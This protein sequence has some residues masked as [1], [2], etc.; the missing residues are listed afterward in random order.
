MDACNEVDHINSVN[1]VENNEDHILQSKTTNQNQNSPLAEKMPQLDSYQLDNEDTNKDACRNIFSSILSK[2][3][4][5]SFI[6]DETDF[7]T[8]INSFI[9]EGTFDTENDL[10]TSQAA[11]IEAVPIHESEDEEDFADEKYFKYRKLD[12]SKLDGHGRSMRKRSLDDKTNLCP[13]CEVTLRP[14][15]VKDHINVEIQKLEKIGTKTNSIYDTSD[16]SELQKQTFLRTMRE[17]R[18]SRSSALA[19]AWKELHHQKINCPVCFSSISGTTDEI[20]SHVDNCLSNESEI[21]SDDEIIN[22]NDDEGYE[23]YTWAGQTRIRASSLIQGGLGASG[24]A[25]VQK[26]DEDIDTDLIVDDD[27]LDNNGESQ[28]LES[29]LIPCCSTQPSEE[30][31]NKA[32]RKAY[33]ESKG[34]KNSSIPVDRKRWLGS[35]SNNSEDSDFLSHLYHLSNDVFKESAL[36]IFSSLKAKIKEQEKKLDSL[37]IPKCLICMESYQKPVISVQ[38]WHVHCEECWLRTLGVKKLCP[39]CNTITSPSDLRIIFL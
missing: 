7:D 14:G 35:H 1:N 37:Q 6:P 9:N 10:Y 2:P 29:D 8:R 38:C 32:L 22:V 27:E 39:Q 30:T 23:E 20:A 21:L 11:K 4:L 36:E 3:I 28:Y 33:L 13:I 17:N 18:Q 26:E 16:H 24:F 15:D 12:Q 31:Q 19:N 34:E 5:S 25:T